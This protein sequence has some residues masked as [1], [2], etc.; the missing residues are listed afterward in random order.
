MW[1]WNSNL[2]WQCKVDDHPALFELA[3]KVVGEVQGSL[4]VNRSFLSRY[5]MRALPVVEWDFSEDAPLIFKTLRQAGAKTGYFIDYSDGE[6]LG[7]N[8]FECELSSETA[9]SVRDECLLGFSF[10]FVDDLFLS[11]VAPWFSDFTYLCMSPSIFD[12]FLLADPISFEL[13]ESETP[14]PADNF[15]A[16]LRA[17]F[18]RL[19]D[20]N[21]LMKR[22]NRLDEVQNALN[23]QLIQTVEGE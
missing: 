4:G 21:S 9:L 1:D 20:W 18:K 5:R 3:S 8:L 19:D 10:I 11:A 2:F 7:Q 22:P 23:W 14:K 6:N 12:K 15:Q 13:S 16:A 17:T